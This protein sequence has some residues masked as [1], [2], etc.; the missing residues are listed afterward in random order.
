MAEMSMSMH[1]APLLALTLDM[2]RFAQDNSQKQFVRRCFQS[3][4]WEN[5]DILSR[6]VGRWVLASI[7]VWMRGSSAN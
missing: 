4:A 6:D 3:T 7:G 2:P 1:S 5:T